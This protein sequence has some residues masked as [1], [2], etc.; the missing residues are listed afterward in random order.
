M[1]FLRYLARYKTRYWAN[2]ACKE[3][4][5]YRHK[6]IVGMS[7]RKCVLL[8]MYV[9]GG[10]SWEGCRCER[11]DFCAGLLLDELEKWGRKLL[12]RKPAD[13]LVSRYLQQFILE[14]GKIFLFFT[15]SSSFLFCISEDGSHN[16]SI[17]TGLKAHLC[18]IPPPPHTL[19]IS[20]PGIKLCF[21]DWSYV[22]IMD[23]RTGRVQWAPFLF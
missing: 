2:K 6:E 21:R 18:R 14:Q 11:S 15:Y 4:Q 23:H 1:V 7:V 9:C 8:R 3:P 17:E 22:S 19:L 5:P 16:S 20:Q 10:R 12:L 13:H